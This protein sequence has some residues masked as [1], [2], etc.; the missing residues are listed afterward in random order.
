[1][2]KKKWRN[3]YKLFRSELRID[4]LLGNDREICRYKTPGAK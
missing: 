1:L 2:E 4:P 3:A